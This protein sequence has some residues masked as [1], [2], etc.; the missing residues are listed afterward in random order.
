MEWLED[1][2]IAF[3]EWIRDREDKKRLEKDKE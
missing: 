2:I 3:L 1:R